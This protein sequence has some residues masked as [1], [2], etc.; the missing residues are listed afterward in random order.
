MW[1]NGAVFWTEFSAL[2][3]QRIIVED[4]VREW[5]KRIGDIGR[6]KVDFLYKEGD[7]PYDI[8]LDLGAD[9]P[10]TLAAAVLRPRT[11][12]CRLSGRL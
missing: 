12:A 5:R 4:F 10:E 2:G 7:V 8:E 6:A 1:E 9:N 11:K 3:C